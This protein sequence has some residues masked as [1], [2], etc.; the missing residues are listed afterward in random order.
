ML[1]LACAGL[2]ICA[3]LEISRPVRT[4]EFV[5]AVGPRAALLGHE[6]GTLEGYV[7]P[8]KIFKDLRLRFVS[9]GQTLPG[10]TLARRITARPGS[11]T[12]TYTGDDFRVSETLVAPIDQAGAL[13]LLDITTRSPLRI[14][15]AFTRDFQLM[16]PAAIGS[17]YVEWSE[18]NKSFLFGADGHPFAAVLGSPDA[19]LLSREHATDYSSST[20][21]V[22]TLGTVNGH[23]ER[24][25]A[26]AGSMKSR[27]DALAAY[28]Q[29]LAHPHQTVEAT[30]RH[31]REYL[32]DTVELS[33][34]DERLQRAYDWSRISMVKGFVD[35]PFLGRGLVAGYGPSK[36]GY[37]PGYSWFFGRDSF[38]TSLAFSASG[39]FEGA[40]SAIAFISK[41]QRDDGKLPHEISQAASF[42]DWFKQFPY[43]YASADA[44]PLYIIAVRDYLAT[45]G[46]TGFAREQAPRLWKA[47]E[48]MRSTLDQAG[49]PKNAGVGHGWVEGGR[50]LPVRTELYQ[51]GCYVEALRALAYIAHALNDETRAASL[52]AEFT[53]KRRA[54]NDVYWLPQ[55][56]AYAFAIGTDG[57][58]INQ[59]SVL[60]T[61]PMWFGL[62]DTAKAQQMIEQLARE[63]HESDWGMRIIASNNP[64]YDP[65]GY[66]YGSVWPLFTGWASVGEYRNHEPEPALGNLR[67]NAWLTLDGAGGNPTEVLS[68]DTYSPLST[69]SPHQIWSAAM[70][71]SPLLRGLLGLQSDALQKRMQ[72][73]PHLP[74]NWQDLSAHHIRF[75]GGRV[76]FDLHRDAGVLELK[77]VNSSTQSF[78]LDF[79]PAYPPC[80]H[81]N[82]ATFNGVSVTSKD[83]RESSDW[84]PHFTV[85]VKSGTSTLAIR[86]S[87]MF[88]YVIPFD[89]PRLAEP[90]ANLKLISERW[91]DDGQTLDLTVQG[92][93]GRQYRIGL[94][95]G[96]RVESVEGATRQEA[97]DLIVTFGGGRTQYVTGHVTIRLKPL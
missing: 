88:G 60:A 35:N 28:R 82:S 13:I 39:D 59:P 21:S 30:E 20:G 97:G 74:A 56:G 25:I 7:Y 89:P 32:A 15:A 54:L 84:H 83:Q 16:W 43:G 51:A 62:L 94:T 72:F 73:E 29:L 79:A 33:L 61:V 24:T 3:D 63:E 5:D 96:D 23:A 65:S 37:R 71:V 42:V 64:L 48:F 19:A 86:H 40:R 81:V 8:L 22:F 95:G 27:D 45:S 49:F 90:S 57:K 18:P 6:N 41:Y 87:G 85:S 55:P 2:G 93:Q 47:L 1:F 14:D 34:P 68:G 91:S 80:A 36:G 92:R 58:P 66:H 67:A 75:L 12:I 31:Y 78:D 69:A 11:Y 10:E 70:V 77:I 17:G 26:L 38:W 52:E 4:W 50:L 53:Q 44:T 76:D 46:D 9:D